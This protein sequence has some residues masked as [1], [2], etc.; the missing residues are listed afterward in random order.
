MP[1]Q[2]RVIRMDHNRR[3]RE[4]V[5]VCSDRLE[6]CEIAQSAFEDER[7][8]FDTEAQYLRNRSYWR[9]EEVEA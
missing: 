5:A 8:H 6:A 1:T 2:Y 4:L 9:V 3:D 7:F